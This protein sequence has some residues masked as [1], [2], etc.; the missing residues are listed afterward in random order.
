MSSGQERLANSGWRWRHSIW[1]LIPPLSLGLLT[2]AAFLY[3]GTAARRRAWQLVAG[4]YFVALMV[5]LGSILVAE[6]EEFGVRDVIAIVLWIITCWIGGTIHAILIR[7]EYLRTLAASRP[8]YQDASVGD[9]SRP[10]GLQPPAVSGDAAHTLG[11]DAEQARLFGI[12]SAP[13]QRR[14]TP[15]QTG[16]PHGP[17]PRQPPPQTARPM[18][19]SPQS[20]VPLPA[21]PK[22]RGGAAPQSAASETDRVP[23]NSAGEEALAALPGLDPILAK[24]LVVERQR[25]GGFDAVEDLAECGVP[26]HVVVRLRSVLTVDRTASQHPPRERHGRTLDL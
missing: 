16:R 25:R 4:G 7:P 15:P 5:G 13:E 20:S 19:P 24:R 17:S 14:E 23:L 8:W 22:E 10:I 1:I 21:H 3:A 9:Q 11:L 12:D 18:P 26:P 2:W 6:L